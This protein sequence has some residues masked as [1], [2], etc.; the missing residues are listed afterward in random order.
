MQLSESQD[1]DEIYLFE[2]VVA[3]LQSRYQYSPD[4]AARLVNEYYSKFTDSA[5]CAKFGIPVQN[6]DFFCHMEARAMTDRVH[7][8]EGLGHLPDERAFVEWQRKNRD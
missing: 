8:Y 2:R 3:H 4:E 7:Y 5:F 6:A 1:D